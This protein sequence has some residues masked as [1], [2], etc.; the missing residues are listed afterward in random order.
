M[1]VAPCFGV[2]ST[3]KTGYDFQVTLGSEQDSATGVHGLT[4]FRF[5]P[6]TFTS[7]Y[8]EVE[9]PKGNSGKFNLEAMVLAAPVGTGNFRQIALHPPIGSPPHAYTVS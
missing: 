1:K 9:H 5:P 2:D 7:V 3:A 6:G 4:V 8:F